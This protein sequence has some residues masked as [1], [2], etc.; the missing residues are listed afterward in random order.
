MRRA[1]LVTDEMRELAA[2]NAQIREIDAVCQKKRSKTA[3]RSMIK[4]L[5]TQL[6]ESPS[7][8]TVIYFLE[9]QERWGHL[10]DAFKFLENRWKCWATFRDRLESIEYKFR[11]EPRIEELMDAIGEADTWNSTLGLRYQICCLISTIT[12]KCGKNAYLHRELLSLLAWRF[13]GVV[14]VFRLV[15]DM[16]ERQRRALNAKNGT[17]G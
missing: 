4:A 7:E 9:I 10:V 11:H 3:T 8:R 16:Q 17:H 5:M 14:N 12:E 1:I 2:F 6:L 15:I 13:S